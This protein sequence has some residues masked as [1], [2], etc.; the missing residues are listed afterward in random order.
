[1]RTADQQRQ[2][3]QIPYRQIHLGIEPGNG[4]GHDAC[5]LRN[6]EGRDLDATLIAASALTS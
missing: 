5:A 1:M 4:Q 6:G 2:K 3:V